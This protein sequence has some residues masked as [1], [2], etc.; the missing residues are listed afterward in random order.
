MHNGGSF[1]VLQNRGSI[2][3]GTVQK[4]FIHHDEGKSLLEKAR[5]LKEA[6]KAA[7][8]KNG[9][10]ARQAWLKERTSNSD[11]TWDSFCRTSNTVSVRQRL[12]SLGGGFGEASQAEDEGLG[13]LMGA[14]FYGG[15]SASFVMKDQSKRSLRR[16]HVAGDVH[17]HVAHRSLT[18]SLTGMLK[19]RHTQTAVAE[20]SQRSMLLAQY[21]Q[22]RK[23]WLLIDPR[24]SR[25]MAVIDAFGLGGLISTALVTP[26]EVAFLPPT[27]EVNGIFI[28]NRLV[29]CLSL[30]HI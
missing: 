19:R 22:Y 7:E 11:A 20:K 18:R 4:K 27:A 6:I 23:K 21:D 24:H 5:A 25:L 14:A 29:D 28:A 17:K 15:K 12:G 2:H 3:W 30:I 13:Q 1:K 16:Q 8:E 9:D 10:L 26:W